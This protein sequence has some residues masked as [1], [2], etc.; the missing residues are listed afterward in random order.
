MLEA[1]LA[2]NELATLL[3]VGF[4]AVVLFTICIAFLVQQSRSASYYKKLAEDNANAYAKL[5]K[6]DRVLLSRVSNT[7]L[8]DKLHSGE[9]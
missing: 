8:I 2:P 7:Q 1:V 5:R 9:Y 6:A 4:A 3:I